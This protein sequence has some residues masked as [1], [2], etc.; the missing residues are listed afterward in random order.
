MLNDEKIDIP[1]H[2]RPYVWTDR[3]VNAFL[4]T[5][6]DGMPTLNLII[7]EEVV[8]GRIVRWLEDG[9]QRFMS[10]KKFYNGEL[11]SWNGKQ[12]ADFS[13]EEKTCFD[14]YLF[15]VTTMEEISYARRV[16]LFQAIQDGEPLTNGQ[17]FHAYSHSP[18]VRFAKSLLTDE[19]CISVWGTCKDDLKKKSLA[20]AVAIASGLAFKNIDAIT[21]SYDLIGKNGL[22]DEIFDIEAANTRLNKLL[23]VYHLADQL[24]PT[25]LA[26]KKPQWDAGKYTGYILYAMLTPDRN[27]N[28]DKTMIAQF[29]AR[30]RR[31]K[32]AIKILNFKK[33][34]T[35]NWNC[36]RW[37]QGLDNLD[38]QDTV[39]NEIGISSEEEEDD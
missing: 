3:K 5:I 26:K 11:G 24:C 14:N 23:S 22:L 1:A 12:F 4:M 19:N 10:V 13:P 33:P 39:E 27:W 38:H 34:P 25:T 32:I 6:M 37:K 7:Y 2:Q 17:R 35:R 9:Q 21:T 31:D 28:D 29:I 36:A 8:N 30:V 16:A 18:V 15:T 20:N